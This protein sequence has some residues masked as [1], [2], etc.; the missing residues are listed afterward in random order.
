MNRTEAQAR[1]YCHSI[2]ADPDEIVWGYW[3]REWTSATRW[4]SYR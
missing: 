3:P 4:C 1:A 2:N